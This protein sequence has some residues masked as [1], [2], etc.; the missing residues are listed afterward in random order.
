MKRW[1]YARAR[2]GLT[3]IRRPGG[4]GFIA[5]SPTWIDHMQS[6]DFYR[7][8]RRKG[9]LEVLDEADERPGQT[10]PPKEPILTKAQ[11]RKQAKTDLEVI[12]E[13]LEKLDA[14]L[15]RLGAVTPRDKEHAA[16][17]AAEIAA[18]ELRSKVH[19]K[20]KADLEKELSAKNTED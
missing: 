4:T 1:W 19:A 10:P 8:V 3:Q 12:E 7:K 17:L 18:L 20:V 14:E 15:K 13:S 11:R 16:I 5:Q 2:E 9:D 6:P